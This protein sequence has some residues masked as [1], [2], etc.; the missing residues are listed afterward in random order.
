MNSELTK[1][2]RRE[3]R[4]QEK[5]SVQVSGARAKTIKKSVISIVV[6]AIIAVGGYAGY[7]YISKTLDIPETGQA[8]PIEGAA[9]V[10]DGAK[11]E[12]RTNPPSSGNH[13]GVPANW[14]VY[15]HEI[16]DEAAVHNLEHGGIWISYK[17]SMPS[18]EIKKIVDLVKNYSSKIILTPRAKNDLPIALVSWG[19][20]HKL[21]SFNEDVIKNF[22][23]KYKNT[24]PETVS[25]NMT[26]KQY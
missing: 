26:G 7:V 1:K 20:I 22:I 8:Y 12:Y 15:D 3:M 18:D 14:G 4:R 2:E 11:V 9:H 13:Y 5:R 6:A 17:P 10:A 24:G 23:S 21:D 19:R 16:P 25:D